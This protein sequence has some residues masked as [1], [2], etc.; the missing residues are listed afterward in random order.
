LRTK[1]SNG[2]FVDDLVMMDLK[3][4]HRDVSNWAINYPDR[5]PLNLPPFFLEGDFSLYTPCVAATEM[6]AT[7]IHKNGALSI[8]LSR[9]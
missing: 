8:L 2:E 1:S 9:Y 5:D 7:M 6:N 4:I 3:N